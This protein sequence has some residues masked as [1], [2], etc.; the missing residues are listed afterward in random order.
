MPS[1][2]ARAMGRTI[3]VDAEFEVIIDSTNAVADRA[4]M[5]DVGPR[6]STAV[7]AATRWPRPCTFIASAMKNA[8]TNMNRSGEPNAPKAWRGS[9]TP[10][11]TVSAAT[12]S[13]TAAAGSAS[14]IHHATA[15]VMSAARVGAGP[16]RVSR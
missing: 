16:S 11:T 14:V 7:A 6:A 15:R 10:V 3:A 2:A 9:A 12:T 4:I 8:P 13:A 5:S 1:D